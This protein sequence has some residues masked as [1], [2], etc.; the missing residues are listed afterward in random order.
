MSAI[1]Y[2]TLADMR[3]QVGRFVGD[4]TAS[5]NT[6]T[7]EW[8]NTHYADIATRYRWPALMRGIEAQVF[9]SVGDKFLYLPKDVAQLYFLLPGSPIGETPHQTIEKFFLRQMELSANQGRLITWSDAGEFGRRAD[10]SSTAELLTVQNVGAG[11]SETANVLLHG[12]VTISGQEKVEVLDSVD[13]TGTIASDSSF[14]FNDFLQASVNGNQTGYIAITGKTS[15]TLYATIEPGERT[16][17]YKRL[18]LGYV[19][20]GNSLTIYYKKAVRR[21]TEDTSVPEL[22]ISHAL[23]EFAIAS[24]FMLER[25]WQGAGTAHLDM[26]ERFLNNVVAETIQQA[27]RIEQAIPLTP[28]YRNNRESVVVVSHG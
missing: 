10:F 3:G 19:S 21:L 15:G 25:K 4:T 2:L 16:A 8:L 14:T 28:S 23:V 6:K 13:L 11:V 24:M 18:R 17:R 20:D 22:P 27:G 7:D 1:N 12:T 5:R 9:T 26:A